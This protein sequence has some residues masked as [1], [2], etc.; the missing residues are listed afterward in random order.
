MKKFFKYLL[1]FIVGSFTSFFLFLVAIFAIIGIASSGSGEEV[2]IKDNTVLV[3]D[4]NGTI[5]ERTDD[6]PLESILSGGK[7]S[8]GLNDIKTA[9][10][11]AGKDDRI[12]GI[13]IETS[14]FAA[15][16]ATVEEIR[17][18]L[19][20]FKETGKFIYSFSPVYTFKSY[21]LASV[22]D[23]IFL[24]P[25]GALDFQGLS[26]THIFFKN[27]LEK[28]GVEMQIF[29]Y[30]EF[31]S[32]VEPYILDKMS[33]PARLQ[34]EVYL[35]SI[36]EN[37]LNNISKSRNISI[38]ELKNIAEKVPVFMNDADILA[39]GLIDSLIYKDQMIDILK[40]ETNTES[41]KDV[42]AV[43]VNKYHKVY[44]PGAKKGLEKNKIAVIYAEGAIDDATS[45]GGID[46]EEL[47]RTIRQARR[48][49]SIKAVVLRVNSPGGSGLGS[50][51]IWRE[52]VETKSVKPI[53]VSMGDLAASGGYY[54]AAGAD[55]I[56]A[57]P[58]TLTGSIGVFG[59]IPNIDK[60]KRKIG[61]NTDIVKTNTFADIP[62]INR[63]FTKDEKV[64]MQNYINNFYEFFLK[65]CADGRNRTTEEINKIAEGRVWTG[66]NALKINLVDKL[67]GIDD[68]IEIAKNMAGVET[69]RIVE[70]P[71]K[72]SFSEQLMKEL[73]ENASMRFGKMFFGQEFE[74]INTIKSLENGYPIQARIPYQIEIN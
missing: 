66:E 54:I 50:E 60:A 41:K 5:S 32:A 44:I 27:L 28:V 71:E 67:G 17:N 11:K 47:S 58:N 7:T 33:E 72:L 8:I 73:K 62:N 35:N 22:A 3:L 64:L 20:K 23:K 48:D 51:I 13:Y 21:Y 36:W 42:N 6:N 68:A 24:N 2:K 56:V 18:D 37:T 45:S 14:G 52:V 34:T 46:S 39:T 43:S 55:S 25:A 57:Q 40:T 1:I 38:Q 59:M 61:I 19:F 26:S 9:I 63:A 31:K 10:K 70:L 49:S 29:K 74:L 15:G 16:F 53:I 12:K 4:L 65:R 69:F 30:G